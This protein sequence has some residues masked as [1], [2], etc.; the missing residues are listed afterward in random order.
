MDRREFLAR[1]GLVATWAAIPVLLTD[2]G[3]KK[4]TAPENGGNGDLSGQVSTN[5][6]HSH[7]CVITHAQ[8]VA[9][10]A[11]VLTLTGAGHTHTVSLTADEVMAIG[12]GT[13]V[14]KD[15]TTDNA[16]NHTVTFN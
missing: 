10:N 11:V 8:I 16:H 3:G 9:Q 5:A 15:S 7:S 14:T 1:A 4:T 6:G 13:Q 2:C 12:D